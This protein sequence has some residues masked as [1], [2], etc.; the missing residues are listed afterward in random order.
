MKKSLGV[1]AREFGISMEKAKAEFAKVQPDGYSKS[2]WEVPTYNEETI[3]QVAIENGEMQYFEW[4]CDNCGA[5]LNH[6][7]F[8]RQ[9]KGKWKCEICGYE[10]IIDESQLRL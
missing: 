10:N 6:Q 5:H 3:N 1:I 9:N 4:Y 7:P 2:K 8:F